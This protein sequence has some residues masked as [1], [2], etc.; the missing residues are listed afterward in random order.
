MTLRRGLEA[1]VEHEVT[2]ADTATSL[3]SG[4]VDV[5]ATPAV[6]ALCERAAVEVVTSELPP[7]HTTVGTKIVLEHLAPTLPG[8]SV[9]AT[10]LLEEVDGRVLRFTV[11]ASDGAGTIARGEHTRAVVDR[12]RFLGGAADRG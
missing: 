5:Y 1:R 10:A 12:A 8:R 4:D 3:G 6:V 11:E 2:A 7:G 9:T